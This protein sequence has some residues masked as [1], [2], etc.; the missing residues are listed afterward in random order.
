MAMWSSSGLNTNV[1]FVFCIVG[2]KLPLK[3]ADR[4]ASHCELVDQLF[5]A[6]DS[7][8]KAENRAKMI[9]EPPLNLP[10]DLSE[11]LESELDTV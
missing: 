1:F 11:V 10:V 3:T 7:Q 8:A 6:E 2:G 5:S 9:K 4:Q